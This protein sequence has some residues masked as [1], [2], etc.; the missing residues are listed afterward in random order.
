MKLEVSLSKATVIHK[1]IAM[2]IDFFHW[3]LVCLQVM[4]C[5]GYS[6]C[7]KGETFNNIQENK[8]YVKTPCPQNMKCIP[9]IYSDLGCSLLKDLERNRDVSNGAN[10]KV[11]SFI[12]LSK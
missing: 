5:E 4:H 7:Y 10:S 3:L 1:N 11:R 8:K 9:I 2:A 12:V 6:I